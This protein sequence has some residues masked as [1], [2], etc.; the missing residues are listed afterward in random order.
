MKCFFSLH[1]LALLVLITLSSLPLRAQNEGLHFERI[2]AYSGDQTLYSSTEIEIAAREL[3]S[4]VQSMN[5][6]AEFRI[7]GVDLL[8]LAHYFNPEEGV[9]AAYTSQLEDLESV[10]RIDP[11]FWVK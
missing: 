5:P 6:S 10:S 11:F 9:D 4:L 8:P 7:G 3:D 1:T 2:A